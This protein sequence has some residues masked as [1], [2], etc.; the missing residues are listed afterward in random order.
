MTSPVWFTYV[1]RPNKI[2]MPQLQA[3]LSVDGREQSGPCSFLIDTAAGVS[4]APES[5]LLS[6]V[7]FSGIAEQPTG[8]V[9]INNKPVVGKP[10]LLTVS[11]GRL[12]PIE[13]TI[14]FTSGDTPW[15]L[16]GQKVFLQRTRA[17][18]FNSFSSEDRKFGLMAR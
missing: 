13:E 10:V 11:I 4:I 12:P 15:G 1:A 7:D 9:D 5:Y 6:L 17:Y 8:C 16:L 3:R 2:F 18:F 14:F